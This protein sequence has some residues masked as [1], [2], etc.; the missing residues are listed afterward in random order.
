MISNRKYMILFVLKYLFRLHAVIL[1]IGGLLVPVI[2][3]GGE[4]DDI[5]MPARLVIYKAQQLMEKNEF[6]KAIGTLEKFQEKCKNLKPGKHD[7]KG[8][9]HYLVEFNLGNCCL[10]IKDFSAA[11]AHYLSTLSINPGF[12]SGWMNLAKCC[13]DMNEYAKAG[14]AFL[15]GYETAEPEKN[16]EM[17][18]YGAVCFMSAGDNQKALGVFKRLLK[19]HPAN[20]KLDWKEALAQIYLA[21]DQPRNALPVIEEL[22][23]KTEGKKR[24]QWQ[25]IR[26]HLYLSLDMNKKAFEYVNRLIQ[27]YPLDPKW[28]KGLAHVY[29]RDNR[30]KGALAALTVKSFLE[31]LTTREKR[32]VADLNMAIDVPIQAVR[33]Y[34]KIAKDKFEPDLAYRIAQGYIRLHRPEDAL[35]C[36]EKG[37]LKEK[38]DQRLILIKGSLLYE[39]E[40]YREAAAA[41]E[42]AASC[43][44]RKKQGRAWLMAGYAAWNAGDVKKSRL[45]FKKAVKYPKQ[46]KA[47]QKALSQ[48]D[49]NN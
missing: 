20:V 12:H 23:E 37:L 35:E 17:L 47:A 40:K 7:S 11:K 16:P 27:E 8:C 25:E 32:I 24:K 48:L 45:A 6:A 46:K 3:H 14:H 43:G 33:F 21:C 34:E 36:V 4:P 30:Y 19:L 18:Y 29:L 5:P 39:L 13:Y 41:F 42:A 15:K 31:P 2:S 38:N 49:L 44:E 10:M 28:W 26:L 9:R 1:I 22:S